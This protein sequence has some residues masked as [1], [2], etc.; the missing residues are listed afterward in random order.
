MA[1]VLRVESRAWSWNKK[2]MFG[3]HEEEEEE[4]GMDVSLRHCSLS[5]PLRHCAYSEFCFSSFSPM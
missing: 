3:N 1:R 5:V 4:E 2:R